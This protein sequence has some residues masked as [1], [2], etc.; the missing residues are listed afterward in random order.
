MSK[1][2][3]GKYGI[4]MMVIVNIVIY[5]IRGRSIDETSLWSL[6]VFEIRS[7]GWKGPSVSSEAGLWFVEITKPSLCKM[8]YHATRVKL[9]PYSTRH[10]QT[11]KCCAET[12]WAWPLLP[13]LRVCPA[14]LCAVQWLES[15][16]RKKGGKECCMEVGFPADW[17]FACLN[18]SNLSK[19]KINH[20]FSLGSGK[21]LHNHGKS[22]CLMGKSW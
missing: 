22:P 9:K 7:F 13:P 2:N 3:E 5:L 8:L 10:L 20:H 19:I 18:G 15:T 1:R 16:A 17:D 11:G 4:S 6:N 14:A 21:R 12:P